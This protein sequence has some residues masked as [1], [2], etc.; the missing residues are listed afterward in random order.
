M[1]GREQELQRFTELMWAFEEIARHRR[2]IHVRGDAVPPPL[3][4]AVRLQPGP[5]SAGVELSLSLDGGKLTKWPRA[6]DQYEQSPADRHVTFDLRT[7]FQWETLVFPAAPPLAR[8][9][10]QWMV[11]QLLEQPA[12]RPHVE[13]L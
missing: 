13:A 12:L 8:A 6:G 11:D 10:L 9:L 5:M 4:F 2:D 1:V 7:G 3:G